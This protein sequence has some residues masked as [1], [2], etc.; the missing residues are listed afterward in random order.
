MRSLASLNKLDSAISTTNIDAPRE[1]NVLSRWGYA[2]A[3]FASL[4]FELW[5]CS[6]SS[7]LLQRLTGPQGVAGTR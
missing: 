7:W 2:F 3:T 1:R 5:E 6:S 4:R